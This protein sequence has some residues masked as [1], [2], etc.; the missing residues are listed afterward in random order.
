MIPPPKFH[1]LNHRYIFVARVM[2]YRTKLNSPTYTYISMG[3]T[4]L[5]TRKAQNVSRG[6]ETSMLEK[7]GMRK[8]RLLLSYMHGKKFPA[9]DTPTLSPGFQTFGEKSSRRVP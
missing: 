6:K 3:Y 1:F 2:R 4:S 9:Q 8:S 5:E 7:L